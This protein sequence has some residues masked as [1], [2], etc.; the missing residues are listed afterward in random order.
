MQSLQ[1]TGDGG[2]ILGGYSWSGISGDKTDSSRGV[3][4]Y[5]IVKIDSSGSIEWDK[6]IG[7]NYSDDLYSLQQTKDGGYILGGTSGSA[8]SGEKTQAARGNYQDYWIVKLDSSGTIE[9]DKTI[10]GNY[11][12]YLRSLQ[13]TSDGGYIL[14]GYSQSGISREKT[15]KNDGGYDYW[16]VKLNKKGHVQWDKTIGGNNDDILYSIKEISK[17]HYVL[18]GLSNSETSYDKT[19]SSRGGYDYWIVYLD[20]HNP[21]LK[22]ANVTN[23]TANNI[24]NN[25]SVYPVPAKMFCM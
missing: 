4:D 17:N 23:I 6:T 9:W 13:Q 25:F 14:G 15:E 12:D 22:T 7:G 2:Y 24:H 21:G 19:D 1:Q 5:W 16:V 11:P 8:I 18:G 10:G 20:Y 3:A